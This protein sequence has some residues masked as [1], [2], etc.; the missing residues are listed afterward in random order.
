MRVDASSWQRR[1]PRTA[2]LFV[3]RPD[4]LSRQFRSVSVWMDTWAGV[5]VCMHAWMH[6][7]MDWIGWMVG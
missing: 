2:S 5:Y 3:E 4:V 7:W 1:A 6:G